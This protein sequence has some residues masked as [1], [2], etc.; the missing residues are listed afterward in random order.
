MIRNSFIFLERIGR[1]AEQNIW[2]Q[3]IRD[4]SSFI[5]ADRVRGISPARKHYYNRRLQEARQALLDHDSSYFAERLPKSE[6]WRLYERFSDDCIFL[7]I[8]TSGSYGDITVI[9]LYDGY[10]VRT[11]VKGQG[12]D[13]HNLKTAL[14]GCKLLV[15]FNGLSFDVP[16][17]D[18][19]FNRI[20]PQVPHLDLRFALARIGF[21]GGLKK[22]E[23]AQGIARSDGAAGLAGDDAVRLW[24]EYCATGERGFLD[25]LVEYNTED[26]VNLKPL[27]GFVFREMKKMMLSDMCACTGST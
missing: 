11:L 5:R 14:R 8:E 26:V 24:H 18:R 16:V 12:L 23:K 4:W 25:L 21:T 2:K 13:K 17:I 27:A 9:G 1:T 15:T 10:D 22:I 3:G 6:V 20:C 7:D 19:Y